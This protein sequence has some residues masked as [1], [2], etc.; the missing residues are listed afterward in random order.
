LNH[1]TKRFPVKDKTM[2]E[3]NN[4]S[5]EKCDAF[6]FMCNVAGLTV[7]HPGGLAA[8]RRLAEAC[9]I[10]PRTRVLDLASGKGTTAVYLAQNYGCPVVGV[11]ISSELVAQATALARK[12][13]LERRVSF[14]EGDALALPFQADEFD[15]VVSQAILVLVDDQKKAVREA[16]RVVR[17]GGMI[18]WIEMSWKQPTTPEFIQAASSRL[19]TSCVRNF[20]TYH[21][22]ET[23]LVGA[24]VRQ[25][26]T[27]P[28]P[29]DGGSMLAMLADEKLLNFS[30]V[31][32]RY[33]TNSQIRK[34]MDTI[35]RFFR[36]NTQYFGYGIYLGQK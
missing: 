19:C 20:H 36:E 29:L 25:L 11:D 22:W 4:C 28:F 9:H 3:A 23:L 35:N 10:G 26:K 8:T 31:M 21:G 24:G 2:T 13:G 6:D 15:V 14:R 1:K 27:L 34:R 30:R 18:G 33:L 7:L 16:L 12:K 32:Y 17:P 5:I